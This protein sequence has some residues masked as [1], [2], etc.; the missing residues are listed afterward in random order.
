M[1]QWFKLRKQTW[2]L[3]SLFYGMKGALLGAPY[4][5]EPSNGKILRFG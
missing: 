2:F 3:P 1:S 4:G 5:E